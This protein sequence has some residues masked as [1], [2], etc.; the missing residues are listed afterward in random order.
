[1]VERW[2]KRMPIFS[3]RSIRTRRQ[4]P[5]LQHNSSESLP[6]TLPAFLAMASKIRRSFC[7]SSSTGSRRISTASKTSPISRSL[8]RRTKWSRTLLLSRSLPT[9]LG[10]STKRAMI[11]WSLI[12]LQAC[13]SRPSS[14]RC[15]TKCPSYSI[16][17]PTW[18]CNSPSRIIGTNRSTTFH[19]GGRPSWLMLTS[20]KMPTSLL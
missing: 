12:S 10:T 9:S 19:S 1:M 17:S 16:L 13:T 4:E 8:T 20:T 3:A 5:S 15:V 14:V 6:G 11:P 7:F 18:H 2:R